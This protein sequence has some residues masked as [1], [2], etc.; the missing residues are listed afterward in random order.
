[1]NTLSFTRYR[2]KTFF[3]R[4]LRTLKVVI[5]SHL[6]DKTFTIW[7]YLIPVDRTSFLHIFV[8]F[9]ICIIIYNG[10]VIAFGLLACNARELTVLFLSSFIRLPP[11]LRV[12]WESSFKYHNTVQLTEILYK[13][14]SFLYFCRW[15]RI[16][17]QSILGIFTSRFLKPGLS[18]CVWTNLRPS[19]VHHLLFYSGIHLS[20]HICISWSS[21]FLYA[22]NGSRTLIW[23]N[24]RLQLLDT[25]VDF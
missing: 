22:L 11:P 18:A 8:I 23:Q 3:L 15:A 4:E 16:L 10:L 21:S 12:F 1:M 6:W 19:Q 5:K 7:D 9:V 13:T 20:S 2:T 17:R 24:P 14:Y 25:V